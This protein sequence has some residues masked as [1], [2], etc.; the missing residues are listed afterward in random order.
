[1]Y[2]LNK[3]QDKIMVPEEDLTNVIDYQIDTAMNKMKSHRKGRSSDMD[4][5]IQS[6][7]RN[8]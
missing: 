2:K 5:E 1:M 3:M 6:G 7:R 8:R 4:Y